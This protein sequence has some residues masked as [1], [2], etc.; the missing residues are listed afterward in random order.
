[1]QLG[2]GL[3][4][5]VEVTGGGD[6]ETASVTV[7]DDGTATVVVGTSPHGQG[8]ET[9]FA[10][11]V[12][13]ELG[14]HRSKIAIVHGDTDLAPFG[15][16]TI[17]SRSAQ[18]GGSAAHGAAA[19]AVESAK[20]RAGELLEADAADVVLDTA[21]GRFSVAGTPA[22][23]LGWADLGTVEASHRFESPGTFA[24]GACVAIV[25]VDTETGLTRAIDLT[26]VDDAGHI[27]HHASAEGQVHGGL[28]LAVAAALYEEMV[29]GDDGVPKTTNFADYLL[30]SAAEVPNFRAIEM[31]TPTPLNPLGV[32]GI[33]E[34]GTVV[35]TP[36]LHSAIIDALAPFGVVHLDLPASPERVWR[37]IGAGGV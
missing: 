6:G 15:G 25:E 21:S 14:I 9:A 12:M 18:L 19:A 23:G 22:K 31:E 36:A 20:R 32:K 1:L 28:G 29:Y 11:L 13:A 16:G 17:G 24:F 34:S 7:H 33:G 37:A 8:H 4:C 30:V 3:S 10:E 2:V 5:T 26:S 35:A 27:L